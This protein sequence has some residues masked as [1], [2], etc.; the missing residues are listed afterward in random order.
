MDRYWVT[1]KYKRVAIVRERDRILT[2]GRLA[3]TADG[4]PAGWYDASYLLEDVFMDPDYIEVTAE[5]ARE[6]AETAGIPL[7]GL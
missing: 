1:R 6:I 3:G 5:A 7:C 2:I 4:S